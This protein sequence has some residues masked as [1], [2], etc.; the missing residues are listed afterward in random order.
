MPIFAL[1]FTKC[2][3]NGRLLYLP[4]DCYNQMEA[5]S[6]TTA[7]NRLAFFLTLTPVHHS[8]SF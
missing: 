1:F 4:S 5:L 7:P 2:S 6:K 3:T 8:P